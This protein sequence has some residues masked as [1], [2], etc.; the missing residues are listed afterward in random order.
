MNIFSNKTDEAA[1]SIIRQTMKVGLNDEGVPVVSFAMNRGKGSGSQS[2]PV[3]E[4]RDYA[5]TL[6]GFADNGIPELAS[7]ERLTAAESVRKTIKAQDGVISFRVKSGKGA[8]PAKVSI[9]QLGEVVSLLSGTV[10]AVEAAAEKLGQAHG[11]E[12]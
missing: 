6:S 2:I 4:F 11:S 8:K 5:E 3:S 10:D 12:E 9:S 1:V 7:E